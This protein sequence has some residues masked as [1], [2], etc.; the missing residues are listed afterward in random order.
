M[1]KSLPAV[2]ETQVLPLVWEDTLEK[3]MAIHS[4]IL[5]WKIP[6]RSMVGYSPWGR[7]ESDM[8]EQ[9]HFQF[10]T[11]KSHGYTLVEIWG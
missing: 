7:R 2:Q 6:W 3:E 10:Q 11:Q 8:T 1:V 9:L 5:V 4:S